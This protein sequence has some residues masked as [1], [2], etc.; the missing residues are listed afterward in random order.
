MASF[1]TFFMTEVSCL[2]GNFT[3]RELLSCCARPVR[4]GCPFHRP[5][6]TWSFCCEKELLKQVGLGENHVKTHADGDITTK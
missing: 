1:T 5:R 2:A 3:E 4:R 6:R